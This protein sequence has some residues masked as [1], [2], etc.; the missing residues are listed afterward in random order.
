MIMM[1]MVG[2]REKNLDVIKF[3]ATNSS[4]NMR[5]QHLVE[6]IMQY[7]CKH[8]KIKRETMK[9]LLN[10]NDMHGKCIT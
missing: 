8:E 1:M 7:K 5:E 3:V 10:K 9:P 6:L 4:S 2:E